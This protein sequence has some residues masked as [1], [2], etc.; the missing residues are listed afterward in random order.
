MIVNRF[1]TC[2]WILSCCVSIEG[3]FVTFFHFANLHILNQP[4]DQR[5]FQIWHQQQNKEDKCGQEPKWRHCWWRK[6]LTV[7]LFILNELWME[8]SNAWMLNRRKRNRKSKTWISNSRVLYWSLKWSGSEVLLDVERNLNQ[9]AEKQRL[10][11]FFLYIH[12]HLIDCVVSWI[13]IERTR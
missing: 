7:L 9:S 12:I 10:R 4:S 5:N 3:V 13:T 11:C 8:M 6:S 1:S 2:Q